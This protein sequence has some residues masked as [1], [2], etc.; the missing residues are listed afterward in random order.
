MTIADDNPT[1]YP[2]SQGQRLTSMIEIPET[3]DDDA[4]LYMSHR[5]KKLS[6]SLKAGPGKDGE[7]IPVTPGDDDDKFEG[8]DA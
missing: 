5:S 8:G 4:E 7:N 6:A 3:E 2:G 1:S